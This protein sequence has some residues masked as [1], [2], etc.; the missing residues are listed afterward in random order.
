MTAILQRLSSNDLKFFT[1]ESG[2]PRQLTI[3]G[4]IECRRLF[5]KEHRS[6]E[7]QYRILI[8]QINHDLWQL[9]SGSINRT[10]LENARDLALLLEQ[11][12][13]DYLNEPTSAAIFRND[14]RVYQALLNPTSTVTMEP[15]TSSLS[16][17]IYSRTQNINLPRFCFLRFRRLLMTA[18]PFMQNF[19]RYYRG[20]NQLTDMTAPLVNYSGW[21]FFIPRLSTS[22]LLIAKH[23]IPNHTWMSQEEM[24]LGWR[25]R[26]YAQLDQ[27]WSELTNDLVAFPIGIYF[28][29]ICFTPNLYLTPLSL[30]YDAIRGVIR[31]YREISLLQAIQN[32]YRS[33][34]DNSPESQGYLLHVNARISFEKKCQ[35][36]AVSH[37][38]L[39]VVSSV[40]MLPIYGN[41]I[42]PLLGAAL[43]LLSTIINAILQQKVSEQ[44]PMD[45]TNGLAQY[46]TKQGLNP[47]G[48]FSH[49]PTKETDKTPQEPGITPTFS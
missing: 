5:V 20:V 15:L 25:T 7:L 6:L 9:E 45:N 39:L 23:L 35:L 48:L 12:Y 22:L 46:Q 1:Q 13:R 49:A 21:I 41:P 30:L 4:N 44:R 26:L 2:G 27:H 29:F 34:G 33:E 42:V 32:D 31:A 8:T 28:C 16:N 10:Q 11:L 43:A 19:D 47:F 36:V 37:A 14:Q 3:Q 18:N 38:I 17:T 40:L 24:D